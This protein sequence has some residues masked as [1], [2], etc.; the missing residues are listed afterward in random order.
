MILHAYLNRGDGILCWLWRTMVVA[1]VDTK[2][3]VGAN[4]EEL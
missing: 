2:I 4:C 3:E 1:V